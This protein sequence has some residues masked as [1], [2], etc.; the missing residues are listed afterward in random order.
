MTPRLSSPCILALL[1]IG[2][3]P[4]IDD[5]DTP[6]DDDDSVAV[7]ESYRFTSRFEDAD[8]VSYSGQVLRQVLISDLKAHVGG[9]T[10]RLNGT[11]GAAWFPV[12]GE[13][14]AE[15]EFYF[16]FDSATSGAIDH[17]ITTTPAPLQTTYDDV[18]IGKDLVG[19]L[20]G[21]DPTGQHTDWSTGFAGWG[22]VGDTTPEDLVRAW[23]AELDAA[24]V[25]WSLGDV[26]LDPKGSPVAAVYVT[27]QGR[28]L[29][30]LLQKF[31]DVAIAFSQGAD[32][33]LDDDLDGKGLRSD[34]STAEDGAPYTALEHAW[35]EG[36]GYFGATR[37]YGAWTD[38]A[39]AAGGGSD[40][41]V[42]DGAI[43]LTSEWLRGHAVN[44]GKRDVGAVTPTDFTQQAWD[45]FLAGRAL[46]ASTTGALSDANA[47]ALAA[48]RDLALDAWERAI[49][50]TVVHYINALLQDLATYPNEDFGDVAKHWSEMKGFALGL[51]FNRRSPLADDFVALHALLGDAPVLSSAAPADV[52][53]W[54]DDLL[55]ARDLM[56]AAYSFDPA[57]LGD[58]DGVGGW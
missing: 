22:A 19:K 9:M 34:H 40:T 47:S 39:I 17:G 7:P 16:A 35:D 11:D 25:A 50:A 8:S 4:V 49:A 53:A 57:N 54:A 58:D 5:D 23:F 48:Q 51:Q 45:A 38:E 31:L 55:D 36:F 3:P 46:L 52:S 10:D 1:L 42:A 14:T 30:Q 6:G 12:G 44:A 43:D 21:N 2:C 20:A 33:Y 29:Q 27:A 24:A 13:V 26:A 15:L 37:D 41:V 32:D 28:D 18:S 56:A